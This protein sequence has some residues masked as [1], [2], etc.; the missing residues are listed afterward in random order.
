MRC[1]RY[2]TMWV[3]IRRCKSEIQRRFSQI[4]NS[5]QFNNI[6][7][8][9]SRILFQPKLNLSGD[10]VY[11]YIDTVRTDRGSTVLP[12]RLYY[13]YSGVGV[14]ARHALSTSP[15]LLQQQRE[16]PNYTRNI[17]HS[18]VT[19]AKHS[20]NTSLQDTD[21]RCVVN[22]PTQWVY[23]STQVTAIQDFDWICDR[24]FYYTLFSR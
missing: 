8:I 13:W 3:K 12:P 7:G 15:K 24:E 19:F 17:P 2:V 22:D 14:P 9:Y 1:H 23:T 18:L 6:P 21:V 16:Q 20:Y 4:S 10:S 11:R 5:C